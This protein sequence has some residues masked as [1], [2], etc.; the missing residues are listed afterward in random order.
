MDMALGVEPIAVNGASIGLTGKMGAV[1]AHNGI[2]ILK[3][4]NLA[5]SGLPRGDIT[6][7][8]SGSENVIL[9][10]HRS[11]DLIF[12]KPMGIILTCTGLDHKLGEITISIAMVID[13]AKILLTA[14]KHIKSIV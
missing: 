2:I 6:I 9:G 10:I 7:S 8:I 13:G 14:H 11:D 12:A 3:V 5:E 4:T 1:A